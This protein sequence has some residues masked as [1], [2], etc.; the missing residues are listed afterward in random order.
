MR[1]AS[2][3]FTVRGEKAN[4]FTPL[5]IE[6]LEER[7][8]LTLTAQVIKDIN[9]APAGI[10][11]SGPVVEMGGVGYFVGNTAPTGGGP[12]ALW[13]TDGTPAGTGMVKDILVKPP[14]PANTGDT[15]SLVN[16]NGTLFFAARQLGS[17]YELWKSD[18][19]TAGTTLLK[20]FGNQFE[21]V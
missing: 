13:R 17:G 20:D 2:R 21:P 12:G 10:F 19:T 9:A 15:A 11:P 4:F 3:Q 7:A 6:P 8:L 5:R 1:L 18:G 16:V 14:D